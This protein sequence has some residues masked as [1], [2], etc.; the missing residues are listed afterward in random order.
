MKSK[1]VLFLNIKLLDTSTMKKGSWDIADELVIKETG[2]K[3]PEWINIL[4]Q[5]RASQRKPTDVV[6]H[7]QSVYNLSRYW[8]RML[9][10]YYLKLI[11]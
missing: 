7:L 10:A 11:V 4:D 1:L 8:A 5:H 9:T 3:I 2:K 6:T